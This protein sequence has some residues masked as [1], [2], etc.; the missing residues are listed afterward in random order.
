MPP[1]RDPLAEARDLGRPML[2]VRFGGRVPPPEEL[3]YGSV[4]GTILMPGDKA[5][6]PP[7][8]G[9]CLPWVG[10]GFYDPILGPRPPTEE[11]FHDGGDHGLRA[12]I[13]PDG[14]LHG[15]DP[16]DTV[17]EYTDAAGRRRVVCSNEVCLCSP[18]FGVMRSELPLVVNETAVVLGDTRSFSSQNLV[19]QGTPSLQK[20]Q[21]AELKSVVSREK[22]SG[23][24]GRRAS[25]GWCACACWRRASWT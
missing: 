14:K 10:C 8:V 1:S 23:S 7:R 20:Q 9:P 4:P 21:Y 2:V 12:G 6:P 22:P 19:E 18:R 16:E 11:C 3:V 17:G 24:T 13:G 25:A 15:L 5:L